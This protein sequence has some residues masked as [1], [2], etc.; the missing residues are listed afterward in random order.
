MGWMLCYSTSRMAAALT[1][2]RNCLAW[3]YSAAWLLYCATTL[4]YQATQLD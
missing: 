4:G 3:I 1:G 2:L